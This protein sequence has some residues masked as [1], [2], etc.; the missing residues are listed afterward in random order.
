VGCPAEAPFPWLTWL[1]RPLASDLELLMVPSTRPSELLGHFGMR[2]ASPDPYT[3]LGVPHLLNFFHGESGFYR[4][5]DLVH[6]PSRFADTELMGN[7]QH[8]SEVV[9]AGALPTHNFHPPYNWISRYREPGRVNLNTVYSRD[10]LRALLN[11]PALDD[12]GLWPHFLLSRRG[13]GEP[14]QYPTALAR[15]FRSPAAL[16]LVPIPELAAAVGSEVDCTILRQGPGGPGRPLFESPHSIHPASSTENSPY[17]RYQQL[18]RL[19]NLVTTRSNV[20]AVWITVGCFEVEPAADPAVHPDG[21]QLAAELGSDTGQVTR[22]RAFFL[23]DRS[24]PV[25]FVRGKDLNLE[26]AVLVR[27]FIE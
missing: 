4:L 27:R 15:P 16:D 24:I 22:H 3:S 13:T 18:I 21:F 7:P 6:V 8:F 19:G 11:R 14:G 1:N 17:F 25:G 20:Y 5:L 26:K 23:F 12:N 9:P 2:P 10:V